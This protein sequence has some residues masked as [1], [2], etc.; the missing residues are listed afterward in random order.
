MYDGT[1]QHGGIATNLILD[2]FVWLDKIVQKYLKQKNYFHIEF[3]IKL[4]L[5]N[6]WKI[7]NIQRSVESVAHV[8]FV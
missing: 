2:T 4:Q 7:M 5:S 6:L 8:A 3:T 1:P